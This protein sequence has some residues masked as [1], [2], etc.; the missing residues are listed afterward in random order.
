MFSIV[1]RDRD[2]LRILDQKNMFTIVIWNGQLTITAS[3]KG[4]II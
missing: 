4:C 1:I 3:L 2:W